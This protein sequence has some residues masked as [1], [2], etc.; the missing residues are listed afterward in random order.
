MKASLLACDSMEIH[1]KLELKIVKYEYVR[2][3]PKRLVI[4]IG[5][6]EI[7]GINPCLFTPEGFK[8]N[9]I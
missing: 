6:L 8:K 3:C 1:K 2:G 7:L 5:L 9:V 4:Q